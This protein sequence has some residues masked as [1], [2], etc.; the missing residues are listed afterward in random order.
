VKRGDVVT[1]IDG[2]P[3]ESARDFFE[4][5]ARTTA[6]QELQLTTV[7][8]RETRKLAVRAEQIPQGFVTSLVSDLLGLS[9]E[10]RTSTAGSR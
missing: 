3:L 7:R 9:L 5:L 4:R 8:N 2:Q 6:G 1:Q 10:G